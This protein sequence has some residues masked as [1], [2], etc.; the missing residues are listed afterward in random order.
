MQHLGYSVDTK[1]LFNYPMWENFSF[2]ISWQAILVN[3][4]IPVKEQGELL[5][6]VMLAEIIV[7]YY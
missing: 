4:E 1:I 5:P 6:K 2:D 3:L 7:C